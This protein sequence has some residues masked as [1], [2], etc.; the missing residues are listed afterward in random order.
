MFTFNDTLPFGK[1]PKDPTKVAWV[2]F[3]IRDVQFEASGTLTIDG[4][5]CD[6]AGFQYI[7]TYG[8][9]QAL[10]DSYS[11][12]TNYSDAVKPFNR[13]YAD[14]IDGLIVAGT[15]KGDAVLAE[16]KLL[17]RGKLIETMGV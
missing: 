12:A 2:A 6:D 17:A 1:K 14:I 5:E 11:D 7:V 8:M 13:R 4:E 15:R 3:H 16:M 10:Q 9:K